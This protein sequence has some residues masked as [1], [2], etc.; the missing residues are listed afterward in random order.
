MRLEI[1]IEGQNPYLIEV[2]EQTFTIGRSENNV[3]K[4]PRE[5][6]SR[7]HLNM[8]IDQG[9]IFVTDLGSA[10]GT[11][12]DGEKLPPH[13]EFQW[14][15]FLS[16]HLS[17]HVSI[18]MSEDVDNRKDVSSSQTLSSIRKKD[19]IDEETRQISVAQKKQLSK[20]PPQK[21]AESKK[22][23][24]SLVLTIIVLAGAFYFQTQMNQEAD[25]GNV[26]T[27]EVRAQAQ[28]QKS[29]SKKELQKITPLLNETKCQTDFEKGL[30]LTFKVKTEI[31]EGVLLK[32]KNLYIFYNFTDRI[33][34]VEF[35]P[36]FSFA[37]D[38]DRQLY[39]MTF[40]LFRPDLRDI[41][42]ANGIESLMMVDINSNPVNILKTV[43]ISSKDL[44]KLTMIDIET[45]FS[46][47]IN[48]QDQTLFKSL[49]L[50]A[51]KQVDAN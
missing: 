43:A 1:T 24:L 25:G 7:T 10:N 8:R 14:Q 9:K 27:E 23:P 36:S 49:V 5:S 34:N 33:K 38:P 28:H 37:T 18:A 13:Q 4:I 31:G 17:D 41:I 19:L 46:N 3:V 29:E 16:L 32:N 26:Q 50:G 22:F 11:F 48:K 45:I 40:M 44:A 15:T 51:I 20:R 21:K 47:L 30:C 35:D 2:K 42:I 6:I 12:I 39:L